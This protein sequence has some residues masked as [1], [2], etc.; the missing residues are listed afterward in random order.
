MKVFITGGGGF[1]A[2]HILHILDNLKYTVDIIL[3]ARKKIIIE[4]N[5]GNLIWIEDD[6]SNKKIL[7]NIQLN[8]IDCIF[9]LA[10]I[11]RHSRTGNTTDIYKTNVDGTL[12][13]INLAHK[14]KCKIIYAS[15]SGIIGTFND[16]NKIG[17]ENTD[18]CYK[19]C[20]YWPY[21]NS[22]LLAETKGIILA[23]KL[24]V[25][26]L[27][28]RPSM[29][30]GPGERN[31]RSTII[32]KN[33]IEKKYPFFLKGGV[34]F[35]D[36]RDASQAFVNAMIHS[37]PKQFYNLGGNN[38]SVYQLFSLLEK[39]SGIKKPTLS[40]YTILIKVICN[41]AQFLKIFL[42]IDLHLPDPVIIEMGTSYWNI[43]GN[44]AIKYLSF[45][46]RSCE[47]TL[48]DTINWLTK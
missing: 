48:Q 21:Y 34:N 39:I 19:K 4:Y 28:I 11:V 14:Y 38:M 23:R 12:N 7:D 29:M 9:H 26:F 17:Y 15:T 22:K 45:K 8:N 33:F 41:I 24:N 37:T 5:N 32:I 20:Q 3:L 40:L 13:M 2:S 35:I 1:L 31:I 18:Y 47:D 43:N 30:F 44:N 46:T 42:K 10:G 6:V 16:N 36:V 27:C 25:D